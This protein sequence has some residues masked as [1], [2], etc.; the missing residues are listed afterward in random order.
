M[1]PADVAG[2][3]L[4]CSVRALDWRSPSAW[5]HD[6]FDLAIAADCLYEQAAVEPLL[7]VAAAALRPGGL[8]LLAYKERGLVDFDVALAVA[9]AARLS[10][11]TQAES[12]GIEVHTFAKE[13]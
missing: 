8:L 11:E 12:G 3:P 1:P 7:A 5:L 2:R 9:T 6:D 13:F 4:Q 10:W